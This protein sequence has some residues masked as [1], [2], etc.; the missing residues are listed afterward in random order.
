MPGSFLCSVAMTDDSVHPPEPHSCA[1]IVLA[2]RQP[3][4]VLRL[5]GRLGPAPVFLHVDAGAQPDVHRD[6]LAHADRYPSLKFLP[7]A[8]S[9]WASWG[10]VEATLSG[11]RAAHGL[12]V[13][14]AVVLSGQDYPLVRASEI[15]AFS[16][17][18]RDQ[19]FV[20]S[21]ELP[22][23]PWGADG[24]MERIRYWHHPIR[25][26]RFRVPVPRRFPSG[27]KPYGGSTYFMLSRTAMGDVLEFVKRRPDVARFYRHVWIP[28][29]MF[30]PTALLNS[31]SRGSVVD[32]NLWYMDWPPAGAKHPKVLRSSD[33]APLLAA[34]GK[35]SSA[36][37]RARAKLFARKFDA[38]VD[39]SI[40]DVLDGHAAQRVDSFSAE[41]GL[42]SR[43]M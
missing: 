43:S 34:S 16:R 2:H 19:S 8:R 37:G 12:S 18:H 41:R 10:I 31:Q 23:S 32:E 25:G 13:D 20:A 40:L 6:L 33:A 14:H 1:F 42:R 11:L 15:S 28:D 7:R 38:E 36:G 22:W 5:I 3:R 29:E 27:V 9:A 35:E 21:W 4:Q 26:R 30:I 17:A 24:G 39:A